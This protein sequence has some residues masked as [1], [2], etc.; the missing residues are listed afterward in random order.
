MYLCPVSDRISL[1][2][3]CPRIPF[4]WIQNTGIDL[5]RR[6]TL[7][8]LTRSYPL[9]H[10]KLCPC[11]PWQKKMTATNFWTETRTYLRIVYPFFIP[12]LNLWK[13]CGKSPG[14]TIQNF[15]PKIEGKRYE[16]FMHALL[17]FT[18]YINVIPGGN[19]I[20]KQI[21]SVNKSSKPPVYS[22]C[23]LKKNVFH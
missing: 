5:D 6:L 23:S 19:S 21:I 20:N 17:C 13:I 15:I 16:V 8:M 22:T 1:S 2:V 18:F 3:V 9:V 4:R 7:R 14:F 10:E 12:M 11:I